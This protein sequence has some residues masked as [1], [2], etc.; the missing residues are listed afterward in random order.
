[1]Q[2]EGNK[3][4]CFKLITQT[5]MSFVEC[6]HPRHSSSSSDKVKTKPKNEVE[7]E[8]ASYAQTSSRSLNMATKRRRKPPVSS[9]KRGG[10]N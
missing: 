2:Q 7:Q 8:E 3:S 10:V 9:G 6:L 1:M 4:H 5:L